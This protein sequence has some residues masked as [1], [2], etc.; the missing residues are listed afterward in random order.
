MAGIYFHIPFCKQA[1]HYCDFHFSTNFR[2]VGE[3][4]AAMETELTLQK[5]YLEGEII[6]TIYFG[7]GTPSSIPTP[8][9]AQLIAQ[10]KATHT[11]S[12]T[13]E[14]SLE[15]NPDDLTEEKIRAWK[16]AGINRLSVGVQSFF[17]VHLKWMNRAHNQTQAIAGLKLAKEIGIT[18]ITMDLIYGIPGMTMNEWKQNLETFFS[19]G[20]PHLS[21]YGLTIESQTHLGHL[22]RT[23]QVK[24][25][26]DDSYNQQ[27]EQLMIQTKAH[28]FDHY[29][30]SNFGQP[31]FYSKH[32][33]AYWF[34]KKYVGI[35]P[36]AHSFNGAE[37]QWNVASNMKYV[38]TLNMNTLAAEVEVLSKKDQFNEH[39]L[40]RLRTKWGIDQNQIK[41]QFGASFQNNLKSLI[42]PYLDSKHV[43]ELENSF[44]LSKKGKYLA[45]KISS[46]LFLID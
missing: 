18:N 30:I 42:Q 46:D 27:F 5:D 23:N 25:A 28:G 8:F 17:D 6:E 9:I 1:C 39:I 45:D 2:N 32:N 12:D 19:L 15:A 3:L 40:T 43:L 34:G 36:S 37:R 7:G 29:E 13:A 35:G 22:V 21:A 20:L 26:K 4:V 16:A 11:V 31:G 24:T 14:I 38:K 10:V 44:I 33:T 41:M